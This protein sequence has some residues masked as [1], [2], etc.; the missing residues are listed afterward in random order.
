VAPGK[1]PPPGVHFVNDG[2]PVPKPKSGA[3]AKVYDRRGPPVFLTPAE[4]QA[5]PPPFL[6]PHE[7][8]PEHPEHDMRAAEEWFF[9]GGPLPGGVTSVPRPPPAKTG[10]PQGS[11]GTLSQAA[12]AKAS[13]SKGPPVLKSQ[14]APPK[15]KGGYPTPAKSKAKQRAAAAMRSPLVLGT[16]PESEEEP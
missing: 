5:G 4:V 15:A 2:P 14:A 10:S 3:T 9:F 1:R 11:T 8:P 12:P 6:R 13:R 16:Q 7:L